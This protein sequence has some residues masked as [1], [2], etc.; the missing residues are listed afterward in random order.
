MS[1]AIIAAQ[2]KNHGLTEKIL[3]EIVAE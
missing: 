1:K 2:A 3:A